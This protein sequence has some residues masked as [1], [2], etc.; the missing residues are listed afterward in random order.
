MLV[1][2]GRPVPV[3][4]DG[5]DTCLSQHDPLPPR[6]TVEAKHCAVFSS[7]TKSQTCKKPGRLLKPQANFACSTQHL[8][9]PAPNITFQNFTMSSQGEASAG[10][11][12]AAERPL[13]QE[14]SSLQPSEKHDSM[15]SS[16]PCPTSTYPHVRESTLPTGQE[17]SSAPPRPSTIQ[18]QEIPREVSRLADPTQAVPGAI[19]SAEVESSQSLCLI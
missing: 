8:C 12:G 9:L 7:E 17:V 1:D 5:S 18:L 19:P 13:P 6:Q 10:P 2:P 15:P 11:S 16:P 3:S 4:R 14:L